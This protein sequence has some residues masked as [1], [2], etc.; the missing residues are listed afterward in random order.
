MDAV[1]QKIKLLPTKD[2]LKKHFLALLFISLI[3]F[4]VILC[5]LQY[6]KPFTADEFWYLDTA[7]SLNEVGRP[8]IN[9]CPNLPPILFWGHPTTYIH[10]LALF[11]LIFPESLLRFSGILVFIATIIIFYFLASKLLD[12]KESVFLAVA[13]YAFNPLAIQ[14]ALLLDIDNTILACA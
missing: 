12:K 9:F 8:L 14:G 5:S 3:V 10:Y 11:L 6:S 4:A 1:T 7:K 13:I 2:F